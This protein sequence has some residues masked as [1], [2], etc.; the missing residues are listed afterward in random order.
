MSLADHSSS[1][2]RHPRR[3][4][5][6]KASV[7]EAAVELSATDKVQLVGDSEA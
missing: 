6:P 3:A 7:L 2:F 5:W 1:Y 4:R